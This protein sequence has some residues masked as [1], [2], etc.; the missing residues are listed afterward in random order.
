[1]RWRPILGDHWIYDN[2]S[3][4]PG[5][6]R[7]GSGGPERFTRQ[8]MM[9]DAREW[10]SYGWRVVASSRNQIVLEFVGVQAAGPNG[11]AEGI[12]FPVIG[13]RRTLTVRQCPG[14]SECTACE[15]ARASQ[16]RI[17]TMLDN[18]VK[19]MR[20]RLSRGGRR[21]RG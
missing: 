5:R 2:V 21:R 14:P 4:R 6:I 10:I 11:T 3:D 1:M 9:Q 20:R 12:G 7:P 18:G 19:Q 8:G 13:E 16:T 15:G 17:Q